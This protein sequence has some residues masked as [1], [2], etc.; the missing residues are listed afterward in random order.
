MIII[1][2]STGSLFNS[3]VSVLASETDIYFI[4]GNYGE[5]LPRVI[6]R[7][8]KAYNRETF[9]GR[10]ASWL[11]F[12]LQVIFCLLLAKPQPVFVV[13]NPPFSLFAV[14]LVSLVK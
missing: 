14:W 8:M 1:N 2:Q 5:K 13:T 11:V 3:L 10:V 12:S 6:N 4:C 9:F 7:K